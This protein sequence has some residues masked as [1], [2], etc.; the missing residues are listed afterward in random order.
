MVLKKDVNIILTLRKSI[1]L[2]VRCVWV[3][4]PIGE[5]LDNVK[6]RREKTGK[7][8]PNVA[9]FQFHKKFEEPTEEECTVIKV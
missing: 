1:K 2:P 9:V 8:V 7:N 4:T 5:A 6:I 3:N